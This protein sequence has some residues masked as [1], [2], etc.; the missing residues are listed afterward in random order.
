MRNV[1]G[2]SGEYARFFEKD[3]AKPRKRQRNAHMNS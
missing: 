2:F 3:A 1:S